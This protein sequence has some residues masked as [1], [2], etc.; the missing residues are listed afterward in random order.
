MVPPYFSEFSVLESFILRLES[1][2]V[3]DI[4]GGGQDQKLCGLSF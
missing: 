4:V 3:E 2:L 1:L